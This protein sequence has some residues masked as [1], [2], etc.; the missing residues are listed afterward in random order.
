[1]AGEA[2]SNGAKLE[3]DVS[4]TETPSWKEI[5]GIQSLQVPSPDTAEI[6][7]TALDSTGMETIPG[8]TDYGETQFTMFLRKGSASGYADNQGELI[9]LAGS[10]AVKNFRVTLPT[11]L[12]SVVI[13]CAG[14]VKAFRENLA[15][16]EAATAEVTIRWTGSPTRT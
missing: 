4:T 12:N 5:G 15:T 3:V 8:M 2:L 1:M 13:T 14:W 10:K 9:T 7:V 6:D 11:G 16:G